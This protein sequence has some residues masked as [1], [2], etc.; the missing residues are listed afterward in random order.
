MKAT[1]RKIQV[2][3]RTKPA[4]FVVPVKVLLPLPALRPKLRFAATE[5]LATALTRR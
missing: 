4:A 2:T 1:T 5:G 3:F